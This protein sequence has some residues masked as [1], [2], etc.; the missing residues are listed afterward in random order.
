MWSKWRK[1]GR[2]S[3]RWSSDAA[4]CGHP[5]KAELLAVASVH[6]LFL[7]N[8]R[9][10]IHCR[11]SMAESDSEHF[12]VIDYKKRDERIIINGA[13]EAEK[14]SYYIIRI[15]EGDHYNKQVKKEKQ[16]ENFVDSC[17]PRPP[18]KVGGSAMTAAQKLRETPSWC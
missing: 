1:I 17:K 3:Q 5:E 16:E 7:G 2:S 8:R 13:D 10:L 18:K 9:K 15:A 14:E 6:L 12:N 4:D 11:P